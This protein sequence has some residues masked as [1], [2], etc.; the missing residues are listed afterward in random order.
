MRK[1]LNRIPALEITLHIVVKE[2]ARYLG[3]LRITQVIFDSRIF[4]DENPIL[5]LATLFETL[6]END[7]KWALLF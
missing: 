7:L 5:K 4:F 6:L 1:C 3:I 2:Y